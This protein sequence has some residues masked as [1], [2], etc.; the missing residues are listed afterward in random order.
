MLAI[1]H[2]NPRRKG[3]NLQKVMTLTIKNYFFVAL[4]TV[5]SICSLKKIALDILLQGLEKILLVADID[6]ENGEW[7][8]T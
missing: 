2:S 7:L 1:V 6:V 4:F 8:F 5:V 3:N